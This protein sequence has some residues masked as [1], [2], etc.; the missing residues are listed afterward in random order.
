MP[1]RP[2]SRDQVWLL[3]PTLEELLPQD[4]PARFVA[5]FVE[6]IERTAW[7]Q[8]GVN[9]DGEA[10]GAPAYHP[11]VLLCVWLYGFMSGVRSARKLEAACRDQIPYLWL[12]GWQ[13]PDHN[14]LW[15]FYQEHRQPMRQLLKRTVQTAVRVG[16]LDLA[17]QAVDGTKIAANAAK[18]RTFTEKGLKGLLERTQAA[19]EQLEAQNTTS[20]QP[21]PVH[22]PADLARAK[23]LQKKV[24]A[25][26]ARVQAEDGP[27]TVNL[28]DEE[29]G[30]VKSRQGIIAGYNAEAA[31]VGLA[32]EKAAGTGL[33][34]TAAEVTTDASDYAEAVPMLAQAESNVGQKAQ[35]NLLDGGY[36]SGE[37]LEACAQQGY[38]V[39]MPEAQSRA[40]EGEYHKDR[41]TYDAQT[42]TYTCPQGQTLRFSCTTQRT[43]REEARV[44]RCTGEVC[45]ACVAFGKCTKDKRQ[46]R[47]LE[48]G[49]YEERLREHRVLMAS[50][51]AKEQYQRRKELVEPV[52]GI[53]KETQGARRFLLRGLEKVQ[54]EW[55]L[56]ATCF[57]LRTLWRVWRRLALAE[58]AAICGVAVV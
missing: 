42:D 45:R 8:L 41:F 27:A 51:G 6:A 2:L 25:A 15:R 10:M 34:I 21:K 31:V 57:N 40:L 22:L 50:E 13:Q 58:R 3:P 11:Q 20:D 26:L 53:L 7:L 38:T 47:S 4:H 1:L 37:N 54:A 35:A 19:I 24:R 52:F 39:L 29:V 36:H 56:L 16:L 33:L 23:S 49:P 17:V 55:A 12:T 30:L 43:G 18:D 28:T 14:T 32:V 9:P 44:Y 48:V 46:G 5:A